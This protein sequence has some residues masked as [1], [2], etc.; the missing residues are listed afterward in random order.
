MQ[1]LNLS[2]DKIKELIFDLYENKQD[3]Y[4]LNNLNADECE[5]YIEDIF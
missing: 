4:A 1:L 5:V 3:T 2:K